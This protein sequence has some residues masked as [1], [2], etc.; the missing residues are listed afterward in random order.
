MV[1]QPFRKCHSDTSASAFNAALS[2]AETTKEEI[3]C[4]RAAAAAFTIAQ[5]FGS[6]S[7]RLTVFV[8]FSSMLTQ[9][10]YGKQ[11]HHVNMSLIKVA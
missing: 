4:R 9:V 1:L 11:A 6:T 3:V 2:A 10:G 5:S 8:S 7:R